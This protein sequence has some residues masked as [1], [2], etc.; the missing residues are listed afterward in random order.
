MSIVA[1]VSFI[2]RTGLF[3]EDGSVELGYFLPLNSNL[4]LDELN[5]SLLPLIIDSSEL[6]VHDISKLEPAFIEES[7]VMYPNALPFALW[8]ERANGM[9]S[10]RMSRVPITGRLAILTADDEDDC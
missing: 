1:V 5:T 3:L 7:P 4:M 6:R 10:T 2:S 9:S 8:H